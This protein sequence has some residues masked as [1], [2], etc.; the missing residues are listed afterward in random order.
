MRLFKFIFFLFKY[1][2]KN[3][4]NAKPNNCMA[5]TPNYVSPYK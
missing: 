4:N 5:K 3:L 2:K 1:C